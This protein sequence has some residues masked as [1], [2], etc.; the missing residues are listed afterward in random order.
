MTNPE[1]DKLSK[2]LEEEI[3]RP[4]AN[5]ERLETFLKKQGLSPDEAALLSG[6]VIDGLSSRRLPPIREI[7]LILTRN[8]DHRCDYCFVEGK[9]GESRMD[10][11]TAL[12]A[13]DF[14]FTLSR[15]ADALKILFFGGE[16]LLEFELIKKITEYAR[17]KADDENREVRFD[18]TTNGTLIDEEKAAFLASHRIRVLLSID[19]NRSTHDRH[20][21]TRD[22]SSSYEKI[23]A[24]IELMKKYQ[25]WLGTRMTVHPDSAGDISANVRHLADLG[26]S[27]FLIG[28][29][30]GIEWSDGALDTYRDEMIAVARWLKGELDRGRD[31]RVTPLEDNLRTLGGKRHIWGCRAGRHRV[32]VDEKGEIYPCSKMKGVDGS[33]GIYRL[34]SLAGG[35]DEIFN[36]CILCDLIPVDREK[37][38]ACEEADSCPGGCYATN[39]QATG[40]IF[41]PDPF[42]CRLK[43]RTNRILEAAEKILGE[44]YYK[45]LA[46]PEAG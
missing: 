41:S 26:I 4:G 32:A 8:C 45:K 39:Y 6:A 28:P 2:A 34:G 15:G 7:E 22:G 36:R 13:V 25:P 1:V 3:R 37:C 17:L 35:L 27:Q 20:R 46:P 5:R 33:R 11:E 43:K 12:R 42:E 21:I 24:G 38:A 23:A 16:P 18:M 29:A 44:E 30:T 31:L 14:L 19:G 9:E 40:S 10:E